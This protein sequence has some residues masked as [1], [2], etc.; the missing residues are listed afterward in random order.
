MPP[1]KEKKIEKENL[2]P[3]PPVVTVM[4]HVDHGKTTLLDQIRKTSVAVKEYGEITQHIGAYQVEVN[5]RKITFIDTPGHEAFAKMRRRGA[6]VTD[7]VVL[8]VAADDGVMPQTLESLEHIK[9]AKLPFIVAINKI[10][11]PSA[12]IERVKKQLVQKGVLLEGMGGDV[13]WVAIS[14]KT[15]QGIGELLEMIQ[16]M[17]EMAELKAE[18]S[19]PLKLA[20]IES[21]L[22]KARGPVATVIVQNGTLKVGKV[23]EVAGIKSKVRAM[24]NDQGKSVEEAG[25]ATPVEILGLEKVPEIGEVFGERKAP[26]LEG[27]NLKIVLKADMSGSLEAILENLSPKVEVIEKGVGGISESDVLL[28]KT[29]G[30]ILVGFNLKTS[31]GLQKLAEE[32]KVKVKTYRL[33]Y[34][35]LEDLEKEITQLGKPKVGEEILGKAQIIAEFPYNKQRILGCRVIEGRVSRND[36]VKIIR[37]DQEIG[38]S[39][40]KSLKYLKEFIAKAERGREC[41]VLLEPLL[42]FSPG[43]VLISYRQ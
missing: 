20:V 21:R 15:G 22:D 23:I 4:G 7:L 41:G 43:D 3:R 8:V 17:A 36:N 10:D 35:L 26:H 11:L 39:K 14:G 42:D 9:E 34:E 5:G 30:A 18:P 40:I 16:L 27:E 6:Q 31:A 25:P 28:A 13:V 1:K 12:N 38:R 29:L 24:F 33:I 32:E 37:D 19:G 2:F